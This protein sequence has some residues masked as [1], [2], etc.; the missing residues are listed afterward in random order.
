M[1]RLTGALRAFA[2]GFG[3]GNVRS[4]QL[5]GMGSTLGIWAYGVA[6][7]VYAYHAG[8]GGA[9]GARTVG[10]LFFA[11][12]AIA[13]LVGPWL[14]VLVDRSSRRRMML[15]ADVIRCAIFAGM[16]AVASTG[17]TAYVIY[18][19]AVTSTVVG[20]LFGPA[21][22][23]LLPSLVESPEELTAANL[24]SNTVASVGMFAGPG[25]A[26]I[27]LALSG[28]RAVFALTGALFLWSALF[29]LH[30]PRDAQPERAERPRFLPELA[31][32]FTTVLRD[33]LSAS[34][35]A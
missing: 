13:A 24:V 4:I 30:V 35:S 7:P 2:T 6:L 5:A 28:P 9:Q 10:L 25:I 29:V 23:A 1:D 17:G 11:R 15:T 16:T 27:L 19:L 33:P 18:V 3:N 12:F 34:W 32:G 22:A 14:G 21:Q 20:Q 26:G 8:G 31:A